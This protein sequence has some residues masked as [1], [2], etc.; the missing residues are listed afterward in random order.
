MLKGNIQR[1]GDMKRIRLAV[2]ERILCSD[3]LS[4]ITEICAQGQQQRGKRWH[5]LCIIT[6][7]TRETISIY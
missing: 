7:E 4:Q 5:F 3:C 1:W 2:K 6:I